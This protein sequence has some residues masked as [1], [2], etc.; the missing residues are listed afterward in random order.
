MSIQRDS[1]GVIINANNLTVDDV[2]M[3]RVLCPACGKHVF[4]QWP[5]GWD[6]HSAYRCD[7]IDGTTITERKASFKTRYQQL[8]R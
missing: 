3:Q 6:A 4:E 2:V 5:G 8:F 1:D 7:G